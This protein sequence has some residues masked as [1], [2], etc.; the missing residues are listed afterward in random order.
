MSCR[1]IC[2]CL[3]FFLFVFFV[4]DSMSDAFVDDANS[5]SDENDVP[6]NTS[7]CAKG[8]NRNRWTPF[9]Q[10]IVKKGE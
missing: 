9:E 6:N 3:I 8:L 4:V 2:V 1:A 10:N 7:I 5:D